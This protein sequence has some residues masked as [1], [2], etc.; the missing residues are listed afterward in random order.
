MATARAST[1]PAPDIAA[2]VAPFRAW[3]GLR[4]IVAEEPT[5][6]AIEQ[7]GAR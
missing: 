2:T 4:V 6:A 3:R 1:P 5:R 7:I